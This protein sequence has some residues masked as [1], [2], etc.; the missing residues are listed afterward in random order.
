MGDQLCWVSSID[1]ELGCGDSIV[2]NL[3]LGDH[4][5]SLYAYDSDDNMA[6]ASI[7]ITIETET[8][9]NIFLPLLLK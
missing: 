5:I 7:T 4:L 8:M 2:S 1:G 3:T 6:S 9:H